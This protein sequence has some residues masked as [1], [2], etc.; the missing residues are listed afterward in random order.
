MSFSHQVVQRI[1]VSS[2]LAVDQVGSRQLRS[3]SYLTHCACPRALLIP[4]I[5]LYFQ[6]KKETRKKKEVTLRSSN[7]SSLQLMCAL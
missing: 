7:I 5:P 1:S 4:L 6:L 3:R 2:K